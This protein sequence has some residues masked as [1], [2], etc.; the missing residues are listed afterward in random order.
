MLH[1]NFL[2]SL[3]QERQEVRHSRAISALHVLLTVTLVNVGS[4]CLSGP[5][6]D[7]LDQQPC[8]G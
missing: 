8:S 4:L 3:S 6:F 5:I 7:R 1:D 2:I